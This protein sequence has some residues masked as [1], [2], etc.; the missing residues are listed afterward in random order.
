MVVF[1]CREVAT[2]CMDDPRDVDRL[3]LILTQRFDIRRRPRRS[4]RA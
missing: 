3:A 1:L 2:L 4:K